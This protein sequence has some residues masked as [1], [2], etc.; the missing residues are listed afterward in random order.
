MNQAH[1]PRGNEFSM[2]ASV[3]LR[4][5]NRRFSFGLSYCYEIEI[6]LFLTLC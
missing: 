3:E 5:W 1:P 4:V 2:M 6:T